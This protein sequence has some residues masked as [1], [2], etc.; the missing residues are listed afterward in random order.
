[1][2]TRSPYVLAI[3]YRRGRRAW[4]PR[5]GG[6]LD[7]PRL[8]GQRAGEGRLSGHQNGVVLPQ[9]FLHRLFIQEGARGPFHVSFEMFVMDQRLAN[10]TDLKSRI[11]QLPDL[12]A[13]QRLEQDPGL[14]GLVL[15]CGSSLADRFA[16]DDFI[17]CHLT[18]PPVE[19]RKVLNF[20]LNSAWG[21]DDKG[22]VIKVLERKWGRCHA[23]TAVA[24]FF[25]FS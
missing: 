24:E 5:M 9:E 7:Y 12:A 25:I 15:H 23:G 1:M 2:G 13:F 3:G 8:A 22:I 20:W 16:E 14:S 11:W 6:G 17:F 19:C 10:E 4:R 21:S 18:D